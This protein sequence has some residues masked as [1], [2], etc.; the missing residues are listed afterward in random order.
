MTLSAD[1]ILDRI[2][3]KSKIAKWRLIAIISLVLA[4]LGFINSGEVDSFSDTY[5]DHIAYAKIEG[6]IMEDKERLDSLRK[7][8][9][10]KAV[11]ALI[12]YI[13]SPGGTIVGGE[14]IY[15]VIK[16][17]AAAKPVVAVMGGMAAS[18]GYMVALPA[19]YIFAYEG[20]ITGSVGVLLQTAEITELA[21]KVGVNLITIKTSELKG[22]P[23]PFEKMTDNVNKYM[24]ENLHIAGGVFLNM[25]KESRKL[26]DI[27]LQ[28]ISTGRIYIGR[29]AIKRKLIDAIG[30]DEDAVKWLKTNGKIAKNLKVK[31]YELIPEKKGFSKYFSSFAGNNNFM[32]IFS[33]G[34]MTLW[35]PTKN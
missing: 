17:I 34:F 23:S 14:S 16:E 12:V 18:G 1:V 19:Q 13:D 8:R 7:I 4:A 5:L 22:S 27:E 20:T 29:E 26:S 25:V 11:K 21:K 3:L 15:K 35:S 2:N 24:Q 32:N 33:S 9:D 10:N 28:E 31:E 30:D 6:F